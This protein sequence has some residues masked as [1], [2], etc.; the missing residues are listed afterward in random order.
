MKHFLY[1]FEDV[2]AVSDF[3]LT[4][5]RTKSHFRRGSV[6]LHQYYNLELLHHYYQFQSSFSEIV[7]EDEFD[8]ICGR[9]VLLS[10]YPKPLIGSE[11]SRTS[12]SLKSS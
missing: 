10:Q 11:A 1:D 7:D 12:I 6:L 9:V 2:M 5:K 3:V 8:V 4:K